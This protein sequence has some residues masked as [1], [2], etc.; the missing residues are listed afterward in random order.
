ML[1]GIAASDAHCA[2]ALGERYTGKDHAAAVHVLKRVD[3]TLARMLKTL[4]DMQSG[5]HYADP[6]LTSDHRDRA[7]RTATELV[8]AARERI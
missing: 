1:A 2:A 5:S 7:I 8:Q 4:V 3:S 6:L